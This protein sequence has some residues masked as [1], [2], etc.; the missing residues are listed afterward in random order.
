MQTAHSETEDNPSRVPGVSSLS[1]QEYP[2]A[3]LQQQRLALSC[4][5]MTKNV[6]MWCEFILDTFDSM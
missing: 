6:M 1:L 4:V 5:K 2:L 3:P